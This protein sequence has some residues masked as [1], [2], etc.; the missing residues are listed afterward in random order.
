MVALTSAARPK[1]LCMTSSDTPDTE[2]P[3]PP[4]RH[5]VDT[6][7]SYDTWRDYAFSVAPETEDH[8]PTE[9]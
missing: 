3:Q 1:G 2:T 4:T 6:P 7:E 5:R 8:P 9:S